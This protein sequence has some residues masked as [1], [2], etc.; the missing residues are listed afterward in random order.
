MFETYSEAEL[1][2]GS[3]EEISSR[4]LGRDVQRKKRDNER[5]KRNTF[6]IG[7]CFVVEAIILAVVTSSMFVWR[8]IWLL[9]PL[10]L[11]LDEHCLVVGYLKLHE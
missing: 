11:V 10:V 9:F 6:G 4:I 2:V 3:P 7:I 5:G 1:M 8:S